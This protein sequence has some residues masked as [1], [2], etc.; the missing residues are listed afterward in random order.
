EPQASQKIWLTLTRKRY[1]PFCKQE[2]YFD[3]LLNNSRYLLPRYFPK[4][5]T[6]NRA[7]IIT[8]V[9]GEKPFMSIMTDVIP[10]LHLVGAGAGS[11]CFPL[12][13]YSADGSERFDN[14]TG[15]A[16]EQARQL[17]GDSV[18]REDL[19]YAVY[20]LLHAPDYR[21]K[22]AENLKRELP[23]L[24]LDFALA[25]LTSSSNRVS[26]HRLEEDV[27]PALPASD[28]F[29]KL[30]RVGRA[31][32]DLHVGYESAPIHPL[33]LRDTTPD[34]L[35]F[36]FRVEKMRWLDEKT[37]LKVNQS[38]ELSGFTPEMFEYKLGNRNALDWVVESYR[39]KRDERS[40]LTS[41][42]N[43]V[44]EQSFI[45]D[46]IGRVATVSLETQRLV[47]E[48]PKLFDVAPA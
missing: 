18:S 42:P 28:I 16:W 17:G 21:L 4:S 1:R 39:V 44:G 19:F 5:E 22:F 2:L 14:I 8:D 36:S 27:S 23:R 41:D 15:F 43:R 38:I 48:L 11:Q 24:P 13:T 9:A 47:G 29:Q 46:L 37:K 26:T 25:G 7:I 3:E 20:A 45:L 30:V 6:Q 31:L 33:S 12:Y 35:K 32:G 34:G 10:D 40:G